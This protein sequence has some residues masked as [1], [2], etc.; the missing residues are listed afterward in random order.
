[1][2]L[3]DFDYELPEELIAQ[4]P[5]PRRDESRLILFERRTG[6]LRETRFVNFPRYLQAGDM[7]VVNESK[8]IPARLHARRRTGGAVEVFLARRLSPGVWRAMIRPSRRIA[9]GE[10]VLVGDEAYPV[11]VVKREG[12]GVWRVALPAGIDER[13]FIEEYGHVPLPPYIRRGD[14]DDDR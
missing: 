5:S 12:R 8:V 1:M 10:V 2:N 14:M 11:T 3:R 4:H 6:E 9:P 7:L 13:E